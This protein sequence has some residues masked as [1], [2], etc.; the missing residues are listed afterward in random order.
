MFPVL[1]PVYGLVAW[2]LGEL[3]P[4]RARPWLV[5][6]TAAFYLYGD[7]PWLLGQIDE[8]WYMPG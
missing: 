5:G 6:A 2:S 7:L 4:E 3:A 8:K 1:V